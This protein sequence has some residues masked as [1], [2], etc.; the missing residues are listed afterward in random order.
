MPN[1]FLS[2]AYFTKQMNNYRKW[3]MILILGLLASG[4]T[5]AEKPK[6]ATVDMQELFREYHRTGAAQKHFNGEY[7]RI[8]K[9]VDEKSEQIKKMR[10]RIQL[11][12]EEIKKEGLSEKDKKTKQQEGQWIAQEMNIAQRRIEEFARVE[13]AQVAQKKVV[14]MQGI[15]AEIKKNVV[16]LSEKMGCDYV[17]DRSGL[18]TNQVGFFLYLKDAID[19][20]AP[21]LKELNKFEP[22]ADTE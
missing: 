1:S 13:R 11:I 3:T 10:I 21:M 20:T 19:I 12:A 17:F 6:M 18:N 5:L 2:E 7:A 14:S 15:M 22:G 16:S 9:S 4:T 8:Q